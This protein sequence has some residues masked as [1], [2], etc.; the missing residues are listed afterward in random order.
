MR[1]ALDELTASLTGWI[2]TLP[3]HQVM[4]TGLNVIQELP[5][6]KAMIWGHVWD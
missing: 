4:D 6:Y 5:D 1:T 3:S 2:V